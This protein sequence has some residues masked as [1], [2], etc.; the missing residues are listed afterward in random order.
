MYPTYLADDR[1]VA[2]IDLALE[3]GALP[4]PAV[5]ILR[6]GRDNTLRAQRAREV[7]HAA[8]I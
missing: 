4:G 5:R 3:G 1:V 6:E 7:D 2:A 8:G